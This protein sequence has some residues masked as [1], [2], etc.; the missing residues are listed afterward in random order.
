MHQAVLDHRQT[1]LARLR[2][3]VKTITFYE[4]LVG[5]KATMTHFR[6]YRPITLQ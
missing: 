5:M 6:H 4:L 1:P 2:A 3:W